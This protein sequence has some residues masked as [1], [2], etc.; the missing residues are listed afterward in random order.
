MDQHDDIAGPYMD[1]LRRAFE[2]AVPQ[3]HYNDFTVQGKVLH[4]Q[5]TITP[6]FTPD[7]KVISVLAVARDITALRSQQLLLAQSE[8]R[9]K[10]LITQ[11][12][13]ATC[14]FV[15]EEMLID[16]A[17]ELM[18]GCWGKDS[19]VI[20]LPLLQA[21]PEL[22]GQPFM[23]ILL[24][25]YRS[26]LAY[27]AKSVPAMLKVDGKLSTYY[28]DFTYKPIF[29][30][31]QQVYGI[32]DMAVDVT[33]QTLYFEALHASEQKVR[34]IISSAPVAMGI[35]MGEDLVI[36]LPNQAFTDIIGK[37]PDIAG[38]KLGELMPELGA[39]GFLDL[40]GRVYKTGESYQAYATP[41][42]LI[43]DGKLSRRYFDV[44]FTPLKDAAGLIYAVLD[45]SV[46]VT[47]AT[48]ARE[49]LDQTQAQLRDVIE[50]A[51]V[52]TWTVDLQT[53]SVACSQ[54]FREW[55]GLTDYQGEI[56]FGLIA[57]LIEADQ[58]TGFWQ[59][60]S[61]VGKKLGSEPYSYEYSVHAR[62]SKTR[63]LREQGLVKYNHAGK[64][65]SITG[66]VQDITVQ[67]RD[68][69][70]LQQQILASSGQLKNSR[71][72]LD[73]SNANLLRFA[74][75]ASHDLQEPL[76]KIHTFSSLLQTQYGQQLGAGTAHLKRIEDAAKRM[77]LLVQ[78][79]LAFSRIS[80]DQQI[81]DTV[82]IN[83]VIDQVIDDL[84]IK[85]SETK[86]VVR[87]ENMPVLKGNRIQLTQLF[88]N[89]V[90]NAIKFSRSDIA[91]IVSMTCARIDFQQLAAGIH[92]IRQAAQYYQIDVKDNGI[93]FDPQYADRIFQIFQRLHSRAEF[94]GTGIGLAI[95]EK[96][97]A[98]HG[99][100]IS[101]TSQIGTGSI[102]S[103]FL[104]I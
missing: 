78:E 50:L 6:E 7:G 90:S 19:S 66:S 101:V 40:L 97:A 96:V 39:Q 79:L 24:Q 34:A 13:V 70:G 55:Y 4:Y 35:F 84:E 42:E 102:F 25:V 38:K 81:H 48:L 58:Q 59:L 72:D 27:Q 47:Q 63:V 46:D 21:V 82:D 11:A 30:E 1:A 91:P 62:D 74:Y 41:L 16:V 15:G 94:E 51:E 10:N 80:T 95:C 23:D 89:L 61:S 37:G 54:R 3:Q 29:D 65:A 68:K 69:A 56:T 36:E 26:G 22:T 43:K 104:P 73:R 45:I 75:V 2:S 88:S 60:L 49:Q 92:P 17:N 52:A 98:N 99:G 31:N 87:R 44:S 64:P 28:F 93:G 9:M 12:P 100:T 85:I 18:L 5:S 32:M 33:A 57:D 67:A 103:I 14:L 8:Q 83:D 53:G 76:R 77:S 86:T 71:L 20:G